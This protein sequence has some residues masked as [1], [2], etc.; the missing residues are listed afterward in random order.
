MESTDG[1]ITPESKFMTIL[2]GLMM[3]EAEDNLFQYKITAHRPFGAL[4]DTLKWCRSN[5]AGEWRWTVESWDDNLG[6]TYNFYFI[7][8]FDC[9]TFTIRWS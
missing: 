4:E 8:E 9:L 3:P 6:A 1:I 5:I 2:S 7:D